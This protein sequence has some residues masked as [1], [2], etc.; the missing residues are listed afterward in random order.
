VCAGEFVLGYATQQ[1]AFPGLPGPPRPLGDASGAI[2]PAWAANGSF[3]V[4]RRLRQLV[5]GFRAFTAASAKAL[6]RP[7]VDDAR[8]AA[9]LVGRWPSG[10]SVIRSPGHDDLAAAEP[11]VRNAFGFGAGNPALGL[12]DDTEGVRCPVAGHVRKVNPRDLDTDQGS[13]SATLARRILRR[14]IPYGPPYLGA[15]ADDAVDRGLL[16]LCYQASI[17]RQFEFLTSRWVND[18]SLPTNPS[19]ELGLGFDMLMGQTY[20]RVRSAFLRFPAADGTLTDVAIG[21][22][23]LDIKDWVIPTGGGYFFAPSISAMRDVLGADQ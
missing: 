21:N 22:A 13:A 1:D 8:V 15:H 4:F 11:S 9:M 19:G 16:F 20:N 2:A 5:G 12:V 3:L 6:A 18:L 23:G 7:D 10:A 17:I 14:G